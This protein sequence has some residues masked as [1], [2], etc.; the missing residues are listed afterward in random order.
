MLLAHTSSDSQLRLGCLVC[1]ALS[2]EGGW[3]FP[4]LLSPREKR[5]APT[6]TSPYRTGV[7]REAVN[8]ERRVSAD[9]RVPQPAK[10]VMPFRARAAVDNV[11]GLR[12]R[13]GASGT[14]LIPLL[15]V[16]VEL[17]HAFVQRGSHSG[18]SLR[19]SH[20]GSLV[21]LSLSRLGLRTTAKVR[22]GC[23]AMEEGVAEVSTTRRQLCDTQRYL[24]ASKVCSVAGQKFCCQ[25]SVGLARGDASSRRCL[26]KLSF[27]CLARACSR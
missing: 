14:K 1:S 27:E 2:R 16:R 21:H 20:C 13:P 6:R 10:V 19:C 23:A 3:E 11:R 15:V 26:I 18:G 17:P 4:G 5:A 12:S 9:S 24:A 8:H 25:A 7:R 22:L